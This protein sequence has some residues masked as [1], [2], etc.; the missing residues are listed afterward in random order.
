MEL[1][2]FWSIGLILFLSTVV[3]RVAGFGGSLTSMPLLVPLIGLS[4]AAPVM[5]LFS[6][7][8]DK[9]NGCWGCCPHNTLQRAWRRENTISDSLLT[10]YRWCHVSSPAHEVSTGYPKLIVQKHPSK[11]RRNIIVNFPFFFPVGF[12]HV[13]V[14]ANPGCCRL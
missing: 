9:K 7:S 12:P 6:G 13:S 8:H 14:L 5:T 10:Y 2:L 1:P 11:G 4:A 3:V